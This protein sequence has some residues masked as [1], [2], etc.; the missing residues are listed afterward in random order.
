MESRIGGLNEKSSPTKPKVPGR[1]KKRGKYLT[2]C[3]DIEIVHKRP[4][5]A[6]QLLLLMNGK[7]LGPVKIGRH[8]VKIQNTCAFDSTAQSLLAA[9][10]DFVLYYEYLTSKNNDLF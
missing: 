9:Y 10:H 5:F 1:V 7:K 6:E 2:A 8:M 3:P 4:K